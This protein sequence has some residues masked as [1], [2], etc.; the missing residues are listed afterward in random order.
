MKVGSTHYGYRS[1]GMSKT[2]EEALYARQ[3]NSTEDMLRI[4]ENSKNHLVL[5]NLALNENLKDNP[6]VVEKLY[7][8]GNKGVIRRLNNLGYEQNRSL[9]DKIFG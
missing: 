2:Q 4:A 5:N 3:T 6:E 9:I 1:Y 7:E 8:T